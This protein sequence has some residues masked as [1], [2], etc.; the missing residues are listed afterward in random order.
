MDTTLLSD[1]DIVSYTTNTTATTTATTT[2]INMP[3]VSFRTLPGELEDDIPDDTCS[4]KNSESL[5][6][7]TMA[8]SAESEYSLFSSEEEDDDDDEAKTSHH[9]ED[10]HDHDIDASASSRDNNHQEG[11]D[12]GAAADTESSASTT[13]TAS[14]RRKIPSSLHIPSCEGVEPVEPS[15]EEKVPE[16]QDSDEQPD[17]ADATTASSDFTALRPSSERRISYQPSDRSM[18]VALS[19]CKPLLRY[20]SAYGKDS[21]I[22]LNFTRRGA[23]RVLPKPNLRAIQRQP[24]KAAL[25][26]SS[27]H[28]DD[29]RN[30]TFDKICIREHKI[31]MGDNPSCSYGTP[32]SL[33][34][35]YMD[36]EAVALTD[37]EM[38]KFYSGHVRSR[39]LRQLYLN[40]YQRRNLL[41]QEGYTLEQIKAVKHETNRARKQRELTRIFAQAKVLVTMEDM[42]ESAGRKMSRVFSGSN[43]NNKNNYQT[44]EHEKQLLLKVMEGDDTVD[45]AHRESHLGPIMIKAIEG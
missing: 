40:H 10:G 3:E 34:W 13:P 25:Q 21:K 35:D 8:T 39:S 22:P 42:V 11:D 32:I 33:D 6:G 20:E 26:R 5:A 30:V 12:G 43:N 19:P 45:T 9:E 4:L 23:V 44:K 24:P 17:D 29:R 36:F 15:E 41:L 1:V 16:D 31:T 37:Y 14:G 18:S 7:G 38:Y 28:K 27:S 2:I